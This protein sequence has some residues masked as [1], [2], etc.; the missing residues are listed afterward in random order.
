MPS[1]Y[2]DHGREIGMSVSSFSESE[3]IRRCDGMLDES[4]M[5]PAHGL[6]HLRKV[7]VEAAAIVR[8]EDEAHAPEQKELMLCAHL[9]GLL[10]DIKRAEKNHTVAGSI[11]AE[12]ILER[13]GMEKRYRDYITAAIR[14][15]E[16]FK[17]VLP[18]ADQKAKL[19]SD[20]LYDADKFRWGPDN[21]T[22]TLW[23][24][25]EASE[26]PADALYCS[27]QEKMKWI[28]RIKDTFR[29]QTGQKYGPE[30]I[31]F[32]IKIGNEIYSEMKTLIENPPCC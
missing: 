7:A 31:D 1:F 32:G 29:T 12:K 26:T 8:I 2:T 24:I 16:A 4:T 27:F 18:S 3:M 11:E 10:H 9:A 28:Q 19:I 30:F 15:H 5:H 13:L 22:R 20:S 23:L 25:I 14:N 17:E 21:F 6:D